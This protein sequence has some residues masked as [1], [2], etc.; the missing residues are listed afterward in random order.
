MNNYFSS[1]N[2]ILEVIRESIKDRSDLTQAVI[3]KELGISREYLN[4]MLKNKCPMKLEQYLYLT[5]R[6]R[7]K[8]PR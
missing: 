8:S 1:M 2:K 3:A 4:R 7:I 5:D 6:L